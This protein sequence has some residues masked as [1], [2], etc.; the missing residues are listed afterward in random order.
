MKKLFISA[1]LLLLGGCSLFPKPDVNLT[2][3]EVNPVS[4]TMKS[5]K[6]M[7]I[8]RSTIPVAVYS[9]RDQTGQYKPQA[10]VSSFSTAVTQGATSMLVQTLLESGWFTPVERE[11]LQNLLT[12][13]KITNKSKGK[14]ELP[15]LTDARL[16]IEGGIIAYET[17]I[18]TGG[19]GLGYYGISASELFREDQV[20]IY[21]RAVDVFT[22][23]VMMSVSTTKRVYS[24]E[25]RAGLFRYISFKELAEAEVGFTTNE[26]VQFCVLSAI[27]LAVSELIQ[28]GISK[29]FW[30]PDQE[31]VRNGS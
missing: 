9:F 8:P 28:Q 17:N 5:I 11:G 19:S 20:T 15:A 2:E 31:L 18:N 13:R 30:R 12:E 29:G 22:G 24:Q 23:K 25:M 6:A 21:L 14:D 4:D 10:N 26:P 16:L 7:P 3:A 27:E 1:I